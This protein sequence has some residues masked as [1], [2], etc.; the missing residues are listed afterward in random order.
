MV[1]LSTKEVLYMS[2]ES[3]WEQLLKRFDGAYDGVSF[4]AER[5]SSEAVKKEKAYRRISKII[6]EVAEENEVEI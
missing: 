6:K 3:A 1:C 5:G 2:Y 4:A